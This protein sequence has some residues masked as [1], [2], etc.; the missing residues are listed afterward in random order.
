MR[1]PFEFHFNKV[2]L[3]TFGGEQITAVIKK[4]VCLSALEMCEVTFCFS[5][6]E[7]SVDV[8]EL[9]EQKYKEHREQMGDKE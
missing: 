1:E 6:H 9:I 7:I 4:A 2:E 3:R 8:R 5:G